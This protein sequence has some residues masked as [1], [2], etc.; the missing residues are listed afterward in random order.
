MAWPSLRRRVLPVASQ[1]APLPALIAPSWPL[2]QIT[3]TVVLLVWM[4]VSATPFI[5]YTSTEWLVFAA[6]AAG[7]MMIGHTGQNWALRYLPAYVVNLSLLGEPVGATL[8]AWLLPGIREVPPASVLVGGA[9]ILV[10]IIMG[11]R[12]R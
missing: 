7:P 3:A 4:L 6:L 2:V 10:G 1:L 8:I 11:M 5:G 9:L 12:R